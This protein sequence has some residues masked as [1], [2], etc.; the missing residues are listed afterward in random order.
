MVKH[1]NRHVNELLI[2]QSSY[3]KDL[4]MTMLCC[5]AQHHREISDNQRTTLQQVLQ[6]L[7]HDDQIERFLKRG[8]TMTNEL[9]M[10]VNQYV[11]NPMA[12]NLLLDALIVSSDSE[13][14][15]EVQLYLMSEMLEVL[16]V[17]STEF[18]FLKQ[19]AHVIIQKDVVQYKTFVTKKPATIKA[20]MFPHLVEKCINSK[21]MTI[22]ILIIFNLYISK[23]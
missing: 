2:Q 10:E 18:S 7:Q 3:I 20:K 22:S 9:L 11:S 14:A 16:Q 6:Q 8:L 1:S 19:L 12:I 17:S 23:I 5:M 4:Y 15:Q 13:E 21:I